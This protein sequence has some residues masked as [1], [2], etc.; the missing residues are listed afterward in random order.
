MANGKYAKR[1][2]RAADLARQFEET[3][4]AGRDKRVIRCACCKRGGKDV[5]VLVEMGALGR[6]R[7]LHRCGG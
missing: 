4:A 2:Q 5:K 6:L 3:K 7:R 1:D